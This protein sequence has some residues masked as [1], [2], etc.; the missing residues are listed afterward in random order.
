MPNLFGTGGGPAST[1]RVISALSGNGGRDCGGVADAAPRDALNR[2]ALRTAGP[3][4]KAAL[5]DIAP[6]T[7]APSQ[8]QPPSMAKTVTELSRRRSDSTSRRLALDAAAVEDLIIVA[9]PTAGVKADPDSKR[10]L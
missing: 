8:P 2:P 10:G 6:G 4:A 3:A 1:P 5:R 7:R 9:R